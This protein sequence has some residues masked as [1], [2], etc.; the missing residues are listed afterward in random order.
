MQLTK[1][2]I[3]KTAETCSH[4]IEHH[5]CCLCPNFLP[6]T[7]VKF[8]IHFTWAIYTPLWL[9]DIYSDRFPTF[10]KDFLDYL[11]LQSCFWCVLLLLSSNFLNTNWCW[12]LLQKVSLSQRFHNLWLF[13]PCFFHLKY[14]PEIVG[15]EFK[16]DGEKK[17]WREIKT[18]VL[19]QTASLN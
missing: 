8:M 1:C 4:Q 5:M 19:Y 9:F 2:K 18:A 15:C 10:W 11:F 14:P 12:F 13:R 7:T 6:I 3:F 16:R 17:V